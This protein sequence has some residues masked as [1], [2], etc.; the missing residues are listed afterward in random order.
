MDIY[1]QEKIFVTILERSRFCRKYY[2][3]VLVSQRA[4]GL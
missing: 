1:K 3:S 4:G 2:D